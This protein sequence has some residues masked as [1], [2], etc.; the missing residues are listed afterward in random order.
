MSV[1]KIEHPS[2]DERR[3]KGKKT[4]ELT[5]TSAHAGWKPAGDR[6][7]P[8]ALL[9]EQNATREPDLVPVRHGR[10]MVS[11]FTFYRG[12]AKIMAADLKRHAE[13]R[14]GRSAL[15]RRP[16]VELRGVRLARA[17]AAVRPERLRRDAARPVRVRPEA[18]VCELHDRG[19]QQRLQQGRRARRHTRLGERLPRG[20]G[21]VRR[22][23]HDGGLVR[24]SV[25]GDADGGDRELRECEQGK[26]KKK[27]RTAKTT[28]RGEG[29]EEG[30]QEGPHARQHA[31]AVEARRARRRPLPDRQPAAHRR[32]GAR[33]GRDVRHLR[34]AVRARDPRAVP[35]LPG[36]VAGRP[37]SPAREVRD[38]RHGAQGRRRGQ[39]RHARVH[40]LAPGARPERST[41]PP[42]QGGDGLG[43]RGSPAEE[44]LQAARRAR[45][46]RAAADAG[47]ERHL[48]GLD[49]GRASE[50]LPLLAPAP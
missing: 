26:S 12:A 23:V 27:A 17:T 41:V 32:P 45:R 10:M 1:T 39:R 13:G 11:P 2:I 18:D 20:D 3:V 31:G 34:R 37:P 43:A 36:D 14:P 4:R 21:R 19:P 24:P 38:H 16:S 29:G 35:R 40:R 49:E 50:P 9:E 22:D 47:R 8:V 48:P 7:D 28:R 46:E 33:P 30:R 44:P 5:A 42:G 25:R 6:P 15:R